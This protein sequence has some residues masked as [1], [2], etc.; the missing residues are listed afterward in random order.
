[1]VC[2]V[3]PAPF[4]T[5][6]RTGNAFRPCSG[7]LA[8]VPESGSAGSSSGP[9]GVRLP[10]NG[11]QRAHLCRICT[12]RNPKM[13]IRQWA[14]GVVHMLPGRVCALQSEQESA[15]YR[16]PVRWVLLPVAHN[17]QMPYAYLQWHLL[18]TFS[19]YLLTTLSASSVLMVRISSVYVNVFIFILLLALLISCSPLFSGKR[20]F[21]NLSLAPKLTSV[22]I[23][24]D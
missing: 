7:A 1:M 15:L 20:K 17:G 19:A 11:V 13:F 8:L 22:C 12:H 14:S 3:L 10:A 9:L 18:R 24:C 4:S 5:L 6:R 21:E 2:I 16:V 23:V